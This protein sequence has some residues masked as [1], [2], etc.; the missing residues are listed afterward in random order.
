VCEFL[1][2]T[3]SGE[4]KKKTF[5]RTLQMARLHPQIN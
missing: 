5:K 1:V 4:P 3:V 2:V